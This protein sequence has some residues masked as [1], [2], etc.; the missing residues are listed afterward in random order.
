[1]LK[2]KEDNNL[3]VKD[4]EFLILNLSE[5]NK[6]CAIAAAEALIFAQENKEAER[7]E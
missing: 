5:E 3:E 4:I 7:R 6:K 1:M 2:T